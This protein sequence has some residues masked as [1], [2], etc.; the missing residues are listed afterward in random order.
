[1]DEQPSSAGPAGRAGLSGPG[2]ETLSGGGHAHGLSASG[3]R[4]GRGGFFRLL[5]SQRPLLVPS[6]WPAWWGSED[7]QPEGFSAVCERGRWASRDLQDGEEASA[8]LRDKPH[9]APRWQSGKE[10]RAGPHA[11]RVGEE[12]GGSLWSGRRAPAETTPE[13]RL[14]SGLWGSGELGRQREKCIAASKDAGQRA[15]GPR[16]VF[17]EFRCSSPCQRNR[18]HRLCAR[19][20][21]GTLCSS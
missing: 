20:S 2:T 4:V 16:S 5:L 8:G 12:A 11:G 13:D 6:L 1:M 3:P 9:S 15:L 18:P 19:L 17:P 10:P 7:T 21:R 14:T